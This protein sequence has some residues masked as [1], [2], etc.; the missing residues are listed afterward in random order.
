MRVSPR[1]LRSYQSVHT[2][3]GI[4]AGLLL[5]IGFFAGALSLFKPAFNDW[6]TPSQQALEPVAAD[7]RQQLVDRVLS[8]FP[9]ANDGFRLSY[10]PGEAP[11]SWHPNG[12]G[13]R[14]KSVNLNEV[15]SY[16]TL[17]ADDQLQIEQGQKN[18]LGGLID[19][20][21]R[22]AGIPGNLGHE[23]IGVLVMGVASTLYFIALVSGLI[24]LLP[25]LKKTLFALRTHK[26]SA[27]FW[28]DSHN[29]S[30][31]FSLPYHL[32][33]AWTVVIF[34][35]HDVLYGGMKLVYQDKP[36]FDF[37]KP[38]AAEFQIEQLPKIETFEALAQRLAPG[39]ELM[40][41]EFGRLQSKSPTLVMELNNPNG[42][43]RGAYSDV[44]YLNPYTQEVAFGS[45]Q[46]TV[47]GEVVKNL[48][49]F[50]FGNFGGDFGRWIFFVLGV[51]GA[52][53]F[54]SGNLLWLEKRRQK[55][56]PQRKDVRVLAGLTVGVSFG[57]MLGAAVA[58]AATKWLYL[59]D[60]SIN[61][62]YLWI[63]YGCFG[64]ALFSCVLLGAARAAVLLQAGLALACLMIPATTVIAVA[65][66]SLGL[67]FKWSGATLILEAVALLMGLVFAVTAKR[68]LARGRHGDANS[69]WAFPQTAP[70]AE[71][72]SA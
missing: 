67:D 40:S 10:E 58:I 25:T 50:H 18:Q 57:A 37:P 66:P 6:A 20:L 34:A 63:Y 30:G 16:A 7:K 27:R 19:Q 49:A 70:K 51:G 12:P 64:G 36:L 28:L 8:E 41:L 54:Y 31:I 44:I 29:L 71:Q 35:F 62:A 26:G 17:T 45:V 21:H 69:V 1:I 65:L 11:I 43:M 52:F 9:A 22:T 59:F 42:M 4:L 15:I 13:P 68:T 53:L 48:F 72:V 23:Q 32:I 60:I 47:Y 56:G 33:I 24:L 46:Q 61:H 14:Q 5:F 39:H 55:V 38:A 2:W 3:T